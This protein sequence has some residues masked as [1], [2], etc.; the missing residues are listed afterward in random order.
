MYY[1]Y[2]EVPSLRRL[3][4]I[5]GDSVKEMLDEVARGLREAGGVQTFRDGGRMLWRLEGI[6]EGEL[7]RLA[8]VAWFARKVMAGYRESLFGFSVVLDHAP[9]SEEE[10][11]F[12]RL[13]EL[14]V[15]LEDEQL[16]LTEPVRRDLASFLE[17]EQRA[18]VARVLGPRVQQSSIGPVY[19]L[20][21]RDELVEPALGALE[22]YIDE[23]E[24]P[25]AVLVYG[26]PAAG[27]PYVAEEVARRLNGRNA[28]EPIIIRG[29]DPV[30]DGFA[31]LDYAFDHPLARSEEV[32]ASK[33]H[34]SLWSS[35]RG[36][37]PE[38]IERQPRERCPDNWD[39]DRLV[40]F[41]LMLD[42][43]VREVETQLGLATLVVESIDEFSEHLRSL[44]SRIVAPYR[45]DRRLAVV[46][47]SERPYVP[48][49]FRGDSCTKVPAAS[50]TNQA[51]REF[52]DMLDLAHISLSQVRRLTRGQ[53]LA[54]YHLVRAAGGQEVPPSDADQESGESDPLAASRCAMGRLPAF[55]QEVLFAVTKFGV[56]L[57]VN[58]YCVA[59]EQAGLSRSNVAAAFDRL[60]DTGFIRG[61]SYPG[62]SVPGGEAV[63]STRLGE[64]A[65]TIVKRCEE[66]ILGMWQSR[67][68]RMTPNRYGKLAAYRDGAVLAGATVVVVHMLLDWRCLSAARHVLSSLE[69]VANERSDDPDSAHV[70]AGVF[71]ACLRAALLEGDVSRAKSV[72]RSWQHVPVPMKGKSAQAQI[73]HERARYHIAF[74]NSREANAVTRRAILEF[75][76]CEDAVGVAQSQL[77]FSS[78]LLGEGRLLEAR[79]YA[80]M[81]RSESSTPFSSYDRVRSYGIEAGICF[82]E[83][84]S[85]RA[86]EC[87]QIGVEDAAQA[88]MREWELFFR[89]LDARFQHELGRYGEAEQRFAV[90][91][92]E[93]EARGFSEAA[94]CFLS[95]SGRCAGLAGHSDRARRLLADASASAERLFF[96]A[97]IDARS[98]RY[99]EAEDALSK[100]A[101]VDEPPP[102]LSPE[103]VSF[104]DGFCSVEDRSL[105]RAT[106]E[107][108]LP[109]LIRALRGYVKA[110]QGKLDEG[111]SILRTMLRSEERKE[112]D[113]HNAFY[114]QL[115]GAV[116]PKERLAAYDDRGTELGKAI[117]Y[118]R[119]R[120]GRIEDYREKRDFLYANVWN[121]ELLRMGA[122]HNLV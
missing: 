61:S 16:W 118:L 8:E 112:F 70:P 14:S 98:G 18:D 40:L 92:A 50:L 65:S 30:T 72:Y 97:E 64:H 22:Q 85:R 27:V 117:K 59:L 87:I 3:Q 32:G 57:D 60:R 56:A 29:G 114:Y 49:E 84:E 122:E 13:C 83:G 33:L 7:L 113:P 58:G 105:G 20:F 99:D 25:S 39:N 62:A 54:V 47:T 96:R 6:G 74:G 104:R 26:P 35:R 28:P 93:A 5:Y 82:L 106:G 73:T 4:R 19:E 115:Y 100:A 46:F 95:W 43:Y 121:S 81:A 107:R 111:V 53:P 89:L 9:P 37:L 21:G 63:L 91:A 116:L 68:R 24:G 76:D 34:R 41:R 48:S 108:V 66:T 45:A 55:D 15:R 12:K 67:W 71:A 110:K 78:V 101:D 44:L 42:A 1:L 36:L 109:A 80:V 103:R 51:I 77:T 94:S 88:G 75:Q 90:A 120:A 23:G 86:S 69:A 11:L 79:D 38:E 10:T 102:L 31:P 17:T 119:K 2:V 52:L